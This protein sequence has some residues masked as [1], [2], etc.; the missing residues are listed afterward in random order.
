ME[1][2]TSQ[3]EDYKSVMLIVQE[4]MRKV[5]VNM[6]LQV[7]DHT[8][9]HANNRKDMNTLPQN[10]SAYP[11]VPALPLGD[12][13]AKSSE[14]KSDGSGGTNYSHYGVLIPG[15]DELLD[16]AGNEPDFEKRVAIIQKAEKKILEDVPLIP[17]STNGY[18]I[19]RDP[20]VKLGFEV[21]SGYAF[22]RLDKAVIT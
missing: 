8:T 18:L 10:S 14:V 4:L 16:Q 15:I 20:K 19:V 2:Y 3:R 12:N 11:P 22:W 6:N 9:F 13:L 1:A 21:K 17:I 7:I 5:G